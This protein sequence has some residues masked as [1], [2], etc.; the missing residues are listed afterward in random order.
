MT[1][2]IDKE[3][4]VFIRYEIK[5]TIEEFILR[6]IVAAPI[7]SER[8]NDLYHSYE[9]FVTKEHPK[10]EI[11]KK[12]SFKVVLKTVLRDKGYEIDEITTNLG[13]LVVG[14]GIHPNADNQN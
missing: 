10:T 1:A 11:L 2:V 3:K 4:H 14:I 9:Q 6:Y 13:V 5:E 12:R 8:L 7:C